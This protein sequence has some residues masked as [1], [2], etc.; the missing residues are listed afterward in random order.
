MGSSP[1]MVLSCAIWGGFRQGQIR[2]TQDRS[3]NALQVRY[4]RKP[5]CAGFPMG[6][7]SSAGWNQAIHLWLVTHFR[8]DEVRRLPRLDTE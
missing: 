6:G 2:W 1:S 3:L 4:E 8:I 7:T 5:A